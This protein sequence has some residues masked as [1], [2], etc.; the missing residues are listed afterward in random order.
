MHSKPPGFD[1]ARLSLIT[2]ITRVTTTARF[3][4]ADSKKVP[5]TAASIAA[6]FLAGVAAAGSLAPHTAAH[7]TGAVKRAPVHASAAPHKPDKAKKVKTKPQ[8]KKVV[9]SPVTKV[10][11]LTVPVPAPVLSSPA[12]S[13]LVSPEPH[14]SSS[15]SAPTHAPATAVAV[16]TSK[17][18]SAAALDVVRS[19]K[20]MNYYPAGNSWDRMW[21][22]YSHDQTET[23]FAA[24]SAMGAN[25]VR[26]IVQPD[27][28]GYPDMTAAGQAAFDDM[29]AVAA[30]HHL[31]VQ[32][33]LFDWWS[34]YSDTVGSDQWLSQ[35]LARHVNDP[36]IGLI[37][38]H[39]EID[40][41]DSSIIPWAIHELRELQ[42]LT[43]N[44]PRTISVLPSSS[45]A[46]LI[47]VLGEIPPSLINVVDLHVYADTRYDVP[48]LSGLPGLANGRPILIGEAGLSTDTS[49]SSETTPQAEWAQS[50]FY[51]LLADET[52]GLGL[53]LPSP[54]IFSDFVADTT[55]Q[56]T[57]S[58]Q[59]F[60]GLHRADGSLK[61]A[62]ADIESLWAGAEAPLTWGLDG[63]FDHE[64]AGDANSITPM[65]GSWQAYATSYAGEASIG[66]RAGVGG[67]P[68]ACLTSTG[69]SGSAYPSIMQELA[70]PD[71]HSIAASTKVELRSGAGTTQMALAFFD[72]AG[73]FISQASSAS[74]ANSVS[75]WQTLSVTA[76][77]PSNATSVQI[78]LK[79]AYNS[80]SAC[81]DNVTADN[82]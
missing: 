46:G 34:R 52:Q 8:P 38:I 27:W 58:E 74:A 24:I 32:L 62:G 60:Y 71:D 59:L 70:L 3:W 37:E 47:N 23:D 54:W 76:T 16:D 12:T 41:A 39:N 50:R 25:A 21:A 61:P 33:T 11:A 64:L 9:K 56:N 36:R 1:P 14:A 63:G 68:A 78:H 30:E 17:E 20:L 67:S 35:L 66:S 80:G 2:A 10:G 75:D 82:E 53:P 45:L 5:I 72:A 31:N 4:A 43:P 40:P 55:P 28:L 48:M 13:G 15:T 29:V 49:S 81:F 77:P 7:G 79:S 26:V 65:F 19:Y 57:P 42:A 18:P 69:G 44:T 51:R 22:N 73:H 6:V